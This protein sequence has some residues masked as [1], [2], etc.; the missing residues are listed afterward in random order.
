MGLRIEKALGVKNLLL[1]CDSK[2]VAG[3]IKGEFE[4]KEEM[5]QKFLKLM[6]LLT[7]EFD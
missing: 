5:M 1:Q 4:A 6:K 2:L 7:Q 3:Q